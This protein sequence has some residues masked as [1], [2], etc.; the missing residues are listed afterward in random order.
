MLGVLYLGGVLVG[1]VLGV[2]WL[3]VQ[4][5][6]VSYRLDELRKLRGQVEETNRKL[7]LELASLRSLSRVDAAARRLGFVQPTPD[8]VRIARE[9]VVPGETTGQ[10][11]AVHA[12][13]S[14]DVVPGSRGRP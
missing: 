10:T 7:H 3:R 5:V 8:Q 6:H 4:A 9:F 14:S 11:A 1:G 2:V 12:A 13:T